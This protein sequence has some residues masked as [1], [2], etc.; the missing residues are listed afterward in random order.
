MKKKLTNCLVSVLALTM[1]LTSLPQSMLLVKA[2][3]SIKEMT[4]V[5]GGDLMSD[6]ESANEQ[7]ENMEELIEEDFPLYLGTTGE[8]S[9]GIVN[10]NVDLV[11]STPAELKSFSDNVKMGDTYAGRVVKLGAD[12][13]FDGISVNNFNPIGSGDYA[14]EGTFDGAGHTISGVV[15]VEDNKSE[16]CGLFRRIASSG[17]VKNLTLSNSEIVCT[18]ELY[19]GGIAGWN[20]GSVYNCTVKNVKVTSN[21]EFDAHYAGGIAAYN[22]GVIDMC[23]TLNGEVGVLEPEESW[24]SACY[25]GGVVGY[26]FNSG[27]V[28]SSLNTSNIYTECSDRTTVYLGGV[29]GYAYSGKIT[30]C[31]NAG[32]VAND[33]Q[34]DVYVGGVAGYAAG[35]SVIQISYNTGDVTNAV[36]QY[37]NYTGALAGYC[38]DSAVVSHCYYSNALTGLNRDTSSTVTVRNNTGKDLADMKLAS[39][40]EELNTKVAAN[41][42]W[43]P[44]EIRA[45]LDYPQHVPVYAVSLADDITSGRVSMDRSLAYAGLTV[46][47]TVTPDTYYKIANVKVTSS[48]GAVVTVSGSNGNY[49]FTMPAEDVIVDVDFKYSKPISACNVTLAQNS[50]TYN[51]SAKKPVPTVKDGLKTLVSGTD[52]TL[53]YSNNTNAGTGKVTVTGKG[54][55][56]GSKTLT[57]SILKA[58]QRLSVTKS[59]YT[60]T[61][62]NSSFSLGAKTT[63]GPGKFTYQ[64]SNTSVVTVGS[65]GTVTIKG[66]GYAKITVTATGDTN[67][68]KETKTVTVIV[69][70]KK[71]KISSVKLVKGRGLKITWT[72]DSR[73]DGYRVEYSKD[74]KNWSGK[75]VSGSANNSTTLTGLTQ[76]AVYYVRVRSYV[77]ANYT[78]YYGEYSDV[79][80]SSKIKPFM[81]DTSVTLSK[82]KYEYDGKTKSPSVKITY[83]GKKL[84]KGTDYTVKYTKNSKIG[85]AKVTITGK[86]N[87]T[88][89]ATKTFKITKI[90]PTFT[91]KTSYTKTHGDKA[92]SLNT[93]LKKGKRYTKLSYKSSNTKVATVS[94]AGK[95]TLKGPGRA[96]ITVT[97]IGNSICNKATRKITV[98]V[99]PKKT[100]IS[101]LKG[102]SGGELIAKWK[103]VDKASGYEVQYSTYS[104]F[105]YYST[106]TVYG[107]STNTATFYLN[108]YQKYYVR[109]R[110]YKDV[111]V[112]G[113]TQR[114]YGAYSKTKSASTK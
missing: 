92:F 28:K 56:T 31:A 72:K 73:A 4:V 43:L 41:A 74:K 95:V 71:Q 42:D 82:T 68:A 53:S 50:F 48:A 21:G 26:C 20:E 79:V 37:Y 99:Q 24:W 93:K 14:F 112:D 104:D 3:E 13:T 84:K 86:G 44:W 64:S 113:I 81:E 16:Y 59:S 85:T 83:G 107:G 66:T 52:Y 30:N 23:R 2:E 63:K 61:Y 10:T 111:T 51:G 5:S 105:Y 77:N 19:V 11:I 87:Y 67:Y 98:T 40:A 62:G 12:I 6:M 109:V 89:T 29:C 80:K 39:F 114:I 22:N 96:V 46:N 75:T 18:G 110:A 35:S 38:T 102:K 101:T 34:S 54:S 103:K 49:S 60:K 1:I 57:F 25:V 33:N 97:A 32:T 45:G 88:G 91:G 78:T 7:A 100:A 58:S 27:E 47:F 70:P 17:V 106:R 9:L 65:T 108:S 90:T 8:R 69:Q 15:I 55:Y 36:E 94:S 76:N